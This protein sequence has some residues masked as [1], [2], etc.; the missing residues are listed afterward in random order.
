MPAE[1]VVNGHQV[2]AAIDACYLWRGHVMKLEQFESFKKQHTLQVV[3]G[4]LVF[5][6]AFLQ[7]GQPFAIVK[8]DESPYGVEFLK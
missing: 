2:Q 7:D 3:D 6:G 4:S 1:Q 5:S 8:I